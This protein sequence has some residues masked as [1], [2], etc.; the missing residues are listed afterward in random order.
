M[1][2]MT[3]LGKFYVAV[4]GAC[5]LLCPPS[6][7][8]TQAAEKGK[9]F[10]VGV[11]SPNNKVP[12]F[13]RLMQGM[14]DT[15]P[16]YNISLDIQ[17]ANDDTNTQI[18][19]VETFMAQGVDLLILMPTQLEAL[20]PIAKSLNESGIPFMTTNR[21]LT[22]Q[23]S[24]KDVGVDMITYVG[25]DDFQGGQ[26]QG[27]LLHKLLGDKGNFVLIQGTLGSSPQIMRQKG[28]EDYIAKNAPGLKMLAAQESKQDQARAIAVMENFL[29]RYAAGQI[30]AVVVQD[31]YSAVGAC[32]AIVSAGRNE[33]LAKVI[34]FDYPQECVDYIK[35]GKMYGTVIQAPYEQGTLSMKVAHEFLTKGR[36]GIAEK[37]WTE[38]PIVYPENVDKFNAAW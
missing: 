15:A 2:R 34:A 1:K 6:V 28:L 23:P 36:G 16:Q 14:Q 19:Q 18:N 8:F 13:A 21:M 24:A 3:R 32:D 9:T 29:T 12:F 5:A 33:L 37:T 10:K 22:A 26:K 7:A 4:L 17:D 30:G 11:C 31:P 35:A 20:I 27:E 38:L 25:C